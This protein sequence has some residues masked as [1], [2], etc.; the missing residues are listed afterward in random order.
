MIT[1][2]PAI[3]VRTL[4]EVTPGSLVQFGGARGF[5]AF[6]PRSPG[7]TRVTV[8]YDAERASFEYR[9]TPV[10]VLDFGADLIVVPNLKSLMEID[11]SAE[12]STEL[13]LV[14]DSPKIVFHVEDGGGSRQLDL[15]TG[16]IEP[17]IHAVVAAFREWTV[18]V[19][20]A[21][22]G[23]LPLIDIG[24]PFGV[25]AEDVGP[26]EPDEV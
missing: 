9:F 2:D 26:L 3:V 15:K 20:T 18:G 7:Q 21:V 23:F 22:G 10:G 1:L 17:L 19:N 12:A 13:L 24:A 16:T 11:P 5:C 6:N 8:M 25:A 14:G 4:D